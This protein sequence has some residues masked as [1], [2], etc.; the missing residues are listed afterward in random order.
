[1]SNRWLCVALAAGLASPFTLPAPAAAQAVERRTSESDARLRS[2][3]EETWRVVP[4]RGGILLV[5]RRTPGDV[6]G[7][8]LGASQ[9]AVDGVVVSGAE[10]VS[11][12]GAAAEPI[13]QLSYFAPEERLRVLGLAA[14][15]EASQAPREAAPPA[16]PIEPA[17]PPTTREHRE[18]LGSRV[19]VGG[20]I[21]VG[22]GEHVRDVVAVFGD[23]ELNGVADG[24]VVAVLGSVRLGPAAAVRG[25]VAA[26][27]GSLTA[28]A[29]ARVSGAI[30]EVA[31][32]LPDIRVT[33][34]QQEHVRVQVVPDWRRI[35]SAVWVGGLV[36]TLL[37]AVFVVFSAVMAPGAVAATRDASRPLVLAWLT[38]LAVQM[39]FLPIVLG[40]AG[41]LAASVIGIPLLAAVPLLFVMLA[42]AGVVG[43]AG[44]CVRA[45]GPVLPDSLRNRVSLLTLAVGFALITGV[46]LLGRFLWVA[47]GG[48]SATGA[49][50]A[51][52]GLLLE[53]AV[54]TVGLGAALLAWLQRRRRVGTAAP[55]AGGELA[56][57]NAE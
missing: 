34:G 6:R 48:G 33:V 36:T 50:L 42:A 41:L 28:P 2:R 16:P 7:V 13:L 30:T 52:A 4:V 9:I 21:V 31:W 25:D 18:A 3:I 46:G 35:S 49:L 19:R 44:V 39:L 53:H 20:S 55:H 15:A 57:Q 37:L 51:L 27:G 29:G 12:L 38:G 14:E 40:L 1:M 8:E 43:F 22:E 17:P 47:S 11:R 5:P 32:A 24:N 10:L 45:S 23:V 54:W 26:I 56:A